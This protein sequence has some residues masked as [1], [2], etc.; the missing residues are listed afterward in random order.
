MEEIQKLYKLINENSIYKF[1]G[2]LRFDTHI[3]SVSETLKEYMS[4]FVRCE[5]KKIR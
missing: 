3:S 2:K 1:W 4:L 5:N